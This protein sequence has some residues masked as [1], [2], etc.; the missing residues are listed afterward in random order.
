MPDLPEEVLP[1]EP[2]QPE[3][4]KGELFFEDVDEK[5][6]YYE[7]VLWCAGLGIMTGTQDRLFSPELTMSR[8]MLV[9]ALYRMAGE[10]EPEAASQ[11]G[12]TQTQLEVSPFDDVPQGAWFYKPVL[13][14]VREGVV[15]GVGEGR[16]AP[17]AAV[18]REELAVI[19]YRMAGAPTGDGKERAID[20]FADAGEV[21]PWAVEGMEWALDRKILTGRDGMILAPGESASRAEVAAMLSRFMDTWDS[22]DNPFGSSNASDPVVRPEN[23]L[24]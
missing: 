4:P 7:A 2:E 18:T 23:P 16:F 14:G 9:T 11:N 10:P 12:E 21:S 24:G 5:T 8:A 3:A 13:W 6:W 20:R 22:D 15:K 19:L 1:P 17:D